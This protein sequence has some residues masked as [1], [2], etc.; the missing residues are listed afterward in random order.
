MAG[1]FEPDELHNE[2]DVLVNYTDIER[3]LETRFRTSYSPFTPTIHRPIGSEAVDQSSPMS[4]TSYLLKAH[5]PTAAPEEEN[6][7]HGENAQYS[8]E[9]EPSLKASM[10][11]EIGIIEKKE[12]VSRWQGSVGMDRPVSMMTGMVHDRERLGESE[13]A[14]EKATAYSGSDDGECIQPTGEIEMTN[15][16]ATEEHEA[17]SNNATDET[18]DGEKPVL[19]KRERKTSPE[20]P[21]GFIFKRRR[22]ARIAA[23][24]TKPE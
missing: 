5:L 10:L 3:D 11:Q 13:I 6:R 9:E 14:T 22:S 20:S 8:S 21:D 18:A 4:T 23:L 19:F 7:A 16:P 17:W 12:Q 1:R 24:L 2:L 15:D